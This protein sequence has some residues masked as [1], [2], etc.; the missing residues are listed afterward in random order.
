MRVLQATVGLLILALLGVVVFLDHGRR[1]P[2]P[3][4]AT[5]AA[6]P[7]LGPLGAGSDAHAETGCQ[8]CHGDEKR[9]LTEAC[10]SCHADIAE[11]LRTRRSVHG[12]LAAEQVRHCGRCHGDHHGKDSRLITDHS[13]EQAGMAKIADYRHQDLGREYRLAGRHT[14]IGCEKCHTHAQD[15]MLA[16]GHKRFLGL[17]QECVSCHED[18]HAGKLPD[19]A[20]CH[21]QEQPFAQVASFEHDERFPLE[22]SHAGVDCKQCHELGSRWAIE[23]VGRFR[24]AAKAT[25]TRQ[26]HRALTVR[27]CVDCHETPHTHGYLRAVARRLHLARAVSTCTTCHSV[28]HR[29]FQAADENRAHELHDVTGFDLVVPHQ[30]VACTGCHPGPSR[31][32]MYRSPPRRQHDCRGCHGDP[33]AGQFD[34][35]KGYGNDCMDCHTRVQFQPATFTEAMHQ[36]TRFPLDGA[37]RAVACNLCHVADDKNKQAHVV[38]RG[39]PTACSKC[40][41]D[42]HEGVFDRRG[43]P[44]NVGKHVGCARCHDTQQFQLRRGQAFDHGRW[45]GFELT[46]AHAKAVCQSC[47]PPT[48]PSHGGTRRMAKAKSDCASCHRDPHAGQFRD[49]TRGGGDA[50]DCSRCHSVKVG[51]GLTHFDHDRD[52]RFKLDENHRSLRCDQCHKRYLLPNGA[53]VVRYKPLGTTCK[54]CHGWED[55]GRNRGRGWG[56]GRSGREGRR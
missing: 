13:F 56:R 3:I 14:V 55:G 26:K 33:H 27:R 18:P 47:H 12:R 23:N 40:H 39:K 35:P 46:G 38:Y 45:T 6:L 1:S 19:C 16:K 53:T 22:H 43:L 42:V 49:T 37:H 20:S 48:K 51:F 2:G 10:N 44:A 41:A 15:V 52:S 28:E 29:S 50:T 7:E 21:G 25:G 17:Q 9:S 4:A 32:S 34:Q 36:H 8:I 5:H 54:D 24:T 31:S 11:Q 30:E